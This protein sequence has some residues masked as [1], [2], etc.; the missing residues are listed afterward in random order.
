MGATSAATPQAESKE[1]TVAWRPIFTDIQGQR[2]EPF[3]DG[4]TR[5]VA[6]IFVIPDCPIAC[7]YM[8][9]I[10][11]LWQAYHEKGIE[12]LLVQADPQITV[13]QARKHAEEYQLQCPVLL[14]GEH[15][16]VK[17]TG[18]RRTPEAAVLSPTGELLYWGRIN[19]QYVDLGKRRGQV[20]SN[21]LRDALDA[22][23]AGRP[24]LQ[25]RTEAIGCFIPG[26]SSGE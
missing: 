11:R 20:T 4:S 1:T 12:V 2:H 21:D 23:V 19:D 17:K 5:A 6:L 9:E 24:V 25:P 3:R 13:E 16:W 10:N 22:I 18:V 15:I 7:S 26:L 8:P 14:D